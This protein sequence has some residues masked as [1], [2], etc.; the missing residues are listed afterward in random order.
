[1]LLQ[2]K[3][4]GEL[5]AVKIDAQDFEWASKQAWHISDRGYVRSST[6]TPRITLHRAILNPPSGTVVDHINGDKLDNRRC[7]LRIATHSENMRNR[8]M[9]K[10]GSKGVTWRARDGVWEAAIKVDQQTIFLGS[11]QDKFEAMCVY[12]SAARHYHGE[13]ARTNFKGCDTASAAEIKERN[14][15]PVKSGTGYIGVTKDKRASSWRAM[16]R[17]AD[18]SLW[19]ASFTSPEVAAKERDK[20][21]ITMQGDAAKL[22]FPT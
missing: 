21:A 11:F 4:K 12:D 7:N 14:R 15:K 1:M 22:N 2:V 9:S 3:K 19:R 16:V 8:K 10:V 17:G 5:V 13:F 6:G 20:M 18:G